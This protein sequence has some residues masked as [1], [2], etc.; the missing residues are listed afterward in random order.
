MKNKKIFLVILGIM[1]LASLAVAI[2]YVNRYQ[3]IQI[4]SNDEP[5]D[6][7]LDFYEEWLGA[8][9]ATDTDPYT[10]KLAKETSILSK[11]LREQLS[12]APENGEIDPVLCQS[13]PPTKISGRI[14]S[15][16]ADTIQILV[17][18]KEPKQPNQTVFSLSRLN[19]GWYIDSILCSKEESGAPQG[20]T[21]EHEGGLFKGIESLHDRD[22]WSLVY[23]Q[24][25]RVYT[26]QLIFTTDSVC[27]DIS[28]NES[29][30]D[31]GLFTEAKVSVTG[32]MTESGVVVKH[33]TFMW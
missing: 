17:L 16:E 19:D 32:E 27:T 10:S 15:E 6:I 4:V 21:F 12:T 9:H 24:D 2:F 29:A 28:G 33:L 8:I 20:S 14:I 18:S 30:C 23:I 31:S 3:N 7:V 11:T 1:T 13:I 22:Y 26:A 25:S 5:I